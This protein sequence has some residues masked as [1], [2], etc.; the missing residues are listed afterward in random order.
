MILRPTDAMA[1]HY[2]HLA[3]S[4]ARQLKTGKTVEQ[5]AFDRALGYCVAAADPVTGAAHCSLGGGKYDFLVTST[6]ASQAPPAVGRALGSSLAH[7]IKVPSLFPKDFVSFVS[8]GDGSVNHAHYLSAL[9]MAEYAQFRKYRV[10][11]VFAITDNQISI[12]LRGY[13]WLQQWKK[14]L[15]MPVFEADGNN[16]L[17]IWKKSG[18]AIDFAR[19]NCQPS[20]IIYNDI[21]RRFGHAATD[22][23]SAY[24]SDAEIA[25]AA[26][27]NPIS[28]ACRTLV[29]AGVVTYQQLHQRF[30]HLETVVH[31]AFQKAIELPK[32]SSRE[33]LIQ[34]NSA[35]TVQIQKP[36]D[37]YVVPVDKQ[38]QVMRKHMTSVID[39]MLTQNPKLVYLGEDVIHGGYYLV[40]DGLAKKFPM[41]VMD[42]PPEETALLG[43]AIGYSQVG[44]IPIVE[45]PYAKYLDCGADMFFEAIIANWLSNGTQ[46][47]GMIIRL[48]G[49]SRGVFGGNYHT[50]NTLH[51][52]PGLD[53]VCYSNG[54]DYARG[55]RYAV[56]QAQAGRVVM[57]VDSTNLLNMRHCLEDGDKAW[58]FPYT[59]ADDIV[60]WTEV[61]QYGNGKKVGIVTYG[62]SVLQALKA[63]QIL[64][65]KY[66]QT[67]VTVID[68]PLLS[69]LS[70]KLAE[71]VPTFENLIFADDCKIGQNPFGGLIQILQQKK[72]LPQKWI[73]VA[74]QPTYNPLGATLTFTNDQDI[75]DAYLQLQSKN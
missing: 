48:Q 53:V 71:L 18:Q 3:T 50:H 21:P 42:F 26:S 58:Q 13:N 31:D 55:F 7:A 40:T 20:C 27:R 29:E 2:R 60:P 30:T 74:A 39:E 10:P 28:Y 38:V 59:K 33:E 44:L 72:K 47:N 22:R 12:S 37:R 69:E 9:N 5:I 35:P 1:L 41:R 57:F 73:S 23:Q 43:A 52:P 70:D 49:F 75:I 25:R 32:L 46:P 14:K 54:P 56:Q 66:N 11:V 4:V 65:E 62:N 63:Q 45:I 15:L 61:T 34:R 8:V 64:K 68:S 36:D 51:L 24:L 19:K 67:E 17:D 6:L 16:F